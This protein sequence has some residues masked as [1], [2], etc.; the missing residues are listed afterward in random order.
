MRGLW[1]LALSIN[2]EATVGNWIKARWCRGWGWSNGSDDVIIMVMWPPSPPEVISDATKMEEVRIIVWIMLH[3]KFPIWLRPLSSREAGFGPHAH[4]PYFLH[5]LQSN[6]TH[7]YYFFIFYF[8][9]F[10]C[11]NCFFYFFFSP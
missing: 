4:S 11:F 6:C 9:F 3:L 5:P 7:A 2:F 1:F 10:T 8:F